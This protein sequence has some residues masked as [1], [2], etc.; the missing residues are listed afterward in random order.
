MTETTKET[1]QDCA[2]SA[3]E[4][5]VR[6]A[7]RDEWYEGINN[8][9]PYHWRDVGPDE[10]WAAAWDAAT[11]AEREACAK[12]C[13]SPVPGLIYERRPMDWRECARQIRA[14]SN[15]TLT[16]GAQVVD[17]GDAGSPSR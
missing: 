14:R 7:A 3:V 10:I 15:A 2:A 4:R 6:D 8:G 1:K 17:E 9:S 5:S 11:L 13:E 12:A 16:R